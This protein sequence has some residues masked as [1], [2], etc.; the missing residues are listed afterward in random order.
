M[1]TKKVQLNLYIPEEHRDMLQRLA[2]KRMLKNP[3]RSA[4]ASKIGAEIICEYLDRLGEKENNQD[5]IA[6]TKESE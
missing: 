6:C 2:G 3:K 4:S 5:E 1:E